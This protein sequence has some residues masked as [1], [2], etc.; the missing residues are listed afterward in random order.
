[1]NCNMK[2]HFLRVLVGARP[3]G[4]TAPRRT[5]GSAHAAVS[6]SGGALEPSGAGSVLV[7]GQ[8]S[9]YGLGRQCAWTV[10]MLGSLTC[11]T[12]PRPIRWVRG[13]RLSGHTAPTEVG[14]SSHPTGLRNP[15]AV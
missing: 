6:K 14:C 13:K 8:V 5:S 4:S 7:L 10:P 1:M 11:A 9:R 2:L 12:L 15:C 3:S